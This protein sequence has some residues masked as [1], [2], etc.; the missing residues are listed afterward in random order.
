M[1]RHLAFR[2]ASI[3][4]AGLLLCAAAAP[5]AGPFRAGHVFATRRQLSL[6]ASLLVCTLLA[7]AAAGGLRP[8]AASAATSPSVYVFPVPNGR[9]AAPSTQITFRGVSV[10]QLGSIAVTGSSSGVHGGRLMGDSDGLGASFLP[11]KPFNPGERV[12]VT[13]HL[14]IVGGSAGSFSFTIATPAG[15]I[16]GMPTRS[17]SR[18]RG[19]VDRFA[20]DPQL[21][22]AAVRVTRLPSRSASSGDIFVATQGGPVQNGPMILGPY[23]GLYWFKPVPRGDSATDFR[24]Q[25]YKGKPVL[26]WWQGR[27]SAAGVG[28]GEDE[29]YDSSYRRVATIRASNG[30]SADLHEFQITPQNT[31]LITAYYPV[32]WD[33]SSVGGSKREIVLD[34]VAQGIDPST[35]LV[36]F[37]WDSLDH[38]PLSDSY[39][40]PPH[41]KGHPYDYFHINSV[42]QDSDGNL[43]ISSRDTWAAYKVS[44]QTGEIMWELNGKH[45][46][47]KM[48]SNATFA[49][50]HDV[51]LRPGNRITIFDDGAGPPAVHKQSRALTLELST[52][53]MTATTV[54]A[55]EHKP[56]LLANYEGSVELQPNGDDFVGWGQQPYFTEFNSRGQTVFDARFVGNNSSYRAFRFDWRGEP[57]DRPG[58][59]A[60]KGAPRPRSTPA[61]TALPSCTGG[62]CWGEAVRHLSSP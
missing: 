44:Y 35:G 8:A 23:G 24:A 33:A 9:V 1:S 7:A 54:S 22:P 32:Y 34:S 41:S 58:V 46:S 14:N 29:I 49:F 26:T 11:S 62:R 55:D 21:V 20:S 50:Q 40:K 43:I 16:P 28:A 15:R 47:F 5:A 61:S 51:R 19:D 17:A 57:T 2:P 59:A 60:R 18:V 31:A 45:S 6:A 52:S 39:T 10:G 25:L 56:A 48:G 42:Q 30:L 53:H 36:V 4:V 12:T 37:Q 27:V 13:T 38:V 3:L